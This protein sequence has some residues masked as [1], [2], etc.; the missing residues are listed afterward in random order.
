MHCP[1][2]C[3]ER[4]GSVAMN[5]RAATKGH[6]NTHSYYTSPDYDF[7]DTLRFL[8][9]DLSNTGPAA[10][11]QIPAGPGLSGCCCVDP[12]CR[13]CGGVSAS[14]AAWGGLN[15]TDADTL[16]C[17]VQLNVS[18]CLQVAELTS[19]AQPG[20]TSGGQWRASGV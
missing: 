11:A 7:P 10:A 16:E 17:V 2:S 13:A 1:L 6:S 9:N 12:G 3:P 19:Q 15:D 18:A 8:A 14:A 5:P 4:P 20:V